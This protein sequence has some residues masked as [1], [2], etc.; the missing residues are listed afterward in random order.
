[1]GVSGRL[2]AQKVA[3]LIRGVANEGQRW[4]K[5]VYLPRKNRKL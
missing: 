3:S 2:A 4:N 1:M 5:F